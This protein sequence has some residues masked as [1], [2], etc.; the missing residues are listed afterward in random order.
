MIQNCSPSIY[1]VLM[2]LF[3]FCLRGKTSAA[4][5]SYITT[6]SSTAFYFLEIKK[7]LLKPL[8]TIAILINFISNY[9]FSSSKSEET[10]FSVKH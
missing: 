2:G 7:K 4:G 9:L 6:V 10:I 1:A 8:H 3:P 5:R